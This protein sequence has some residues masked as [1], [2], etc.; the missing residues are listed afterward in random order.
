MTAETPDRLCFVAEDL[1]RKRNA[2]VEAIHA[3]LGPICDSEGGRLADDLLR[4]QISQWQRLHQ[5]LQHINDN[6]NT[7]TENN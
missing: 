4:K 7:N 1:L 5:K 3:A 6:T 2:L